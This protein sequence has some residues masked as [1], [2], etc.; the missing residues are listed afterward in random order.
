MVRLAGIMGV[1]IAGGI[2]RPGDAI[3]IS[4]PPGPHR[5][6]ERV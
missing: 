4:L 2:V 6:L 1:V 5:K 3:A